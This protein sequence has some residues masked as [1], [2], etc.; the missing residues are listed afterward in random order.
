MQ[1]TSTESRRC[2]KLPEAHGDGPEGGSF[3]K[4]SVSVWRL[5]S[6]IV[7]HMS[8]VETKVSCVAAV[9]ESRAESARRYVAE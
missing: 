5:R 3:L 1:I 6:P 2:K 7:K 8:G 9:A 4:I